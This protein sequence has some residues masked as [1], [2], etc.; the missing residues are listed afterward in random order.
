M[1][2]REHEAIVKRIHESYQQRLADACKF[3]E[4]D[5]DTLLNVVDVYADTIT[6]MEE[7]IAEL[8]KRI[9]GTQ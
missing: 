9:K 8:E 6:Q 2:R 4:A 1:K 5:R 3:L 7:R